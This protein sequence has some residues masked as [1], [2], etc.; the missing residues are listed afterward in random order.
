MYIYIY[1]YISVNNVRPPFLKTVNEEFPIHHPLRKL[2]KR[3]TVKISYSCTP[4]ILQTTDAY[5]KRTY[6]S[7]NCEG[8]RD[9]KIIQLQK[10]LPLLHEGQMSQLILSLPSDCH[11]RGQK[12][13]PNLR[14]TNITEDTFKTRFAN[15]KVTFNDPNKRTSTELS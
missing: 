13:R 9:S 11:H 2:F 15:N 1:I 4:N 8:R 12:T 5:K 6:Q 3:N 14:R 10:P 7:R